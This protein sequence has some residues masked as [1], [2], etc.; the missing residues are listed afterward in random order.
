MLCPPFVNSSF[1]GLAIIG[2]S[3]GYLS[4]FFFLMEL[5][6]NKSENKNRDERLKRIEKMVEKWDF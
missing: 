6:R 2:L 1:N 5:I 3:F 4:T